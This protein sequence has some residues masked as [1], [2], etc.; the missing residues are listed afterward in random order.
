MNDKQG[1][2]SH[3]RRAGVCGM[4]RI[5]ALCQ[6]GAYKAS[7]GKEA[8][9]VVYPTGCVHGCKGCGSLCL[10]SA[11]SYH[12]DDGSAGIDYSFETYKPELSCPGKSKV[13]FMCTH[14]ACRSQIAEALGR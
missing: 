13:A 7:I 12:G 9:D 6:H 3:H 11:V 8:P 2:V 14:S 5:L 10:A 1:L 4:R